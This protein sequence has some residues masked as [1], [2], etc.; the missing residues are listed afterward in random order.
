V[1]VDLDD[2]DGIRVTVSDN[3]P[4]I[5]EDDVEAVFMDGFTSKAAR[6]GLRRGLGLAIVQRLVHRAGG[7]ITVRSAHGATFEVRL[8]RPSSTSARLAESKE[9]A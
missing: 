1:V 2:Q 4:G 6:H 5:P 9:R 8:P 7:T 3:G